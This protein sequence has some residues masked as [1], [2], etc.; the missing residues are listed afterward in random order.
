MI[1]DDIINTHNVDIQALSD[2]ILKNLRL[3][4]NRTIQE[5]IEDDFIPLDD[6]TCQERMSDENISRQSDNDMV[7]IEDVPDDDEYTFNIRHPS[8]K[9]IPVLKIPNPEPNIFT[10]ELPIKPTNIPPTA[11]L[12]ILDID[13]QALSDNILKNLRQPQ[14]QQPPRDNRNLEDLI[15]DQFIPLDD[16]DPTK[17]AKD[18]NEPET[19]PFPII[20]LTTP[21]DPVI[22]I[23]ATD[24]CVENK[25]HIQRPG[26]TYKL[27]TDYERKVRAV[28]KIKNKYLRK[29]VGQRK[30]VNKISAEWLKTAG[31]LDT[32]DQDKIN[33]IFVPPKKK[34]TNKIQNT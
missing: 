4:D 1:V 34:T 25:T 12:E 20:T 13:I 2:N 7:T 3:R 16:R 15:D 24:A 26:P 19:R 32:T 22:E 9:A 30:H 28:N 17:I 5:L 27:S 11:P 33:Y 23:D 21:D 14:Q 18:E 10:V 31:Y 29:K 8:T 6:R